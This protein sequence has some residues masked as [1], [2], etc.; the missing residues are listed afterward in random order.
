MSWIFGSLGAKV[1]MPM[2]SLLGEDDAL[3]QHVFVP[4]VVNMFEVVAALRA[5]LAFDVE[6]VML[7]DLGP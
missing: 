6:A 3:D 1:P 5:E 2:R 7:F 4:A